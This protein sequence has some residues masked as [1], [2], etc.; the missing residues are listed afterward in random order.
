MVDARPIGGTNAALEPIGVPGS[1][2]GYNP[3]IPGLYVARLSVPRAGKYLVVAEP[4]GGRPI[5]AVGSLLVKH[6]TTSPPIG[7]KAFPSRTPHPR[8]RAPN[9]PPSP[10][11]TGTWQS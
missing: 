6:V 11:S 8:Q 5:Q 2:F 3:Q 7:S 1:S 9:A 10:A 4:I